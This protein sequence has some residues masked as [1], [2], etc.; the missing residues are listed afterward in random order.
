MTAVSSFTPLHLIHR[1][2]PAPRAVSHVA[3]NTAS[4]AAGNEAG[5][6]DAAAAE[7]SPPSPNILV[8][9][10]PTSL[11]VMYRACDCSSA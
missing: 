1:R 4:A 7:T 11:P 5:G 8:G 3:H 9:T 6:V 10:S 2:R